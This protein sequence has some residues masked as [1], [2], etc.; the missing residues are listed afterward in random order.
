MKYH[1]LTLLAMLVSILAF[2]WGIVWPA[3]CRFLLTLPLFA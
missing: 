1:P 3:F 2:G